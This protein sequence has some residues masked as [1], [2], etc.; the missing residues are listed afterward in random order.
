M[1]DMSLLQGI[2]VPIQYPVAVTKAITMQMQ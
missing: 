1:M 2:V